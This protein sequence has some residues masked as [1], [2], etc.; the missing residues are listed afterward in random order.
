MNWEALGAIGEILG[1]IGV[2][3]TLAYLA[4]QIR[5]NTRAIRG[6]TLSAL[7]QH[8]QFEIHWSSELAGPLQ[9]AIHR[10]DEMSEEDVWQVSELFT[11]FFVAR[12]NEFSQYKQGLLGEE[13]WKSRESI[14]RVTLGIEWAQHWWL[15]F[16]KDYFTTEFV[17]LVG[18]IV[19]ASDYDFA[20]TMKKFEKGGERL[21]QGGE[22]LEN[23]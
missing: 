19:D 10:P 7:T 23:E 3:A 15:T 1:A 18:R 8:Q 16:G 22:S 12:Q 14:I 6:S 17:E 13:D 11:A 5:Q 20:E 21:E 2:I 9:R 4:V